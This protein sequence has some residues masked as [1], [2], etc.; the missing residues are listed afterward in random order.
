MTYRFGGR[1]KA[2]IAAE[3][4]DKGF[5]MG[6]RMTKHSTPI[7]FFPRKKESGAVVLDLIN[8]MNALP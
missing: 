3:F 4:I 5:Y 1:F 6:R 7:S 8:M 2:R